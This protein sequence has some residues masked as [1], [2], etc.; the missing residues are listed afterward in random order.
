MATIVPVVLQARVSQGLR[1]VS[2]D[3]LSCSRKQ[4]EAL[5]PG[6]QT[7]GKASPPPMHRTLAAPGRCCLNSQSYQDQGWQ[8]TQSIWCPL[9]DR[10]SCCFLDDAI[11]YHVPLSGTQV[12]VQLQAPLQ[13]GVVASTQARLGLPHHSS[14]NA[15]MQ[16]VEGS[17]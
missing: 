1:N 8:Q 11:P 7:P 5:I 16:Q 15:T 12:S 17:D 6:P 10:S 2:R 13:N 4:G 9:G 14:G 3:V